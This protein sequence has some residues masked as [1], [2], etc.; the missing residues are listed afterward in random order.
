MPMLGTLYLLFSNL[1]IFTK[2]S[3]KSGFSKGLKK[4]CVCA[5]FLKVHFPTTFTIISEIDFDMLIN[6]IRN[7]N[8]GMIM[9]GGA[10]FYG[11][12]H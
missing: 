12:E 4:K 1:R 9:C 5:S 11:C 6:L 2:A 7:N 10:F 3:H 8:A